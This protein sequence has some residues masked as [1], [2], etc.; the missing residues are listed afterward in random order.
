[1]A[2]SDPAEE[3]ALANYEL[4][5]ATFPQLPPAGR[6]VRVVILHAGQFADT[7][8][9]TLVN[10]DL[11]GTPYEALSYTWGEQDHDLKAKS[12]DEEWEDVEGDEVEEEGMP[13]TPSDGASTV[14]QRKTHNFITV[15]SMP[16][17]VMANLADALRH[18]RLA[19]VSRTLWIDYLCINQG[20]IQDR[21]IQ[22][23][24]MDEIYR[25]ASTVIVWLGLPS[26]DS[27]AGLDEVYA[28]TRN[29]HL[30]QT[31][32]SCR[33]H[34]QLMTRITPLMNLL[35]RPWFQRVWV[36]QEIAL[37]RNVI[38][39]I[40]TQSV[41]WNWFAKAGRVF[42]DHLEC[43]ASTVRPFN[44]GSADDGY[45]NLR[46]VWANVIVL[47]VSGQQEQLSL[48]V[49]LRFFYNRLASDPRDKVYALLGL[50]SSSER[51]LEADYT[52]SAAAVYEEVAIAIL[53]REKGL[54]VLIDIDELAGDVPDTPSWA[55]DW[56][57][58][59]VFGLNIWDFYKAAGST[60]TLARRCSPHTLKLQGLIVDN[61]TAVV[62]NRYE[63]GEDAEDDELLEAYRQLVSWETL[64]DVKAN[65]DA[66]Y[67]SGGTRR[68][69]FWQTIL[70]GVN[71]ARMRR[72]TVSSP[73][74]L[75]ANDDDDGDDISYGNWRAWLET[76]A[77]TPQAL[78]PAFLAAASRIPGIRAFS[79]VVVM[80]PAA[81]W[82]FVTEE[83]YMGLGPWD[84]E[85]G[86]VLVILAGGKMP[87]VLRELNKDCDVCNEDQWCYRLMGFA[88]AHGV[89]DGEM[90]SGI[91]AGEEEWISFCLR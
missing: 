42:H 35:S 17:R 71:A 31:Y 38:V 47:D 5:Y 69:A 89:M 41:P 14:D 53:N 8:N 88:Y 79:D 90:V 49:A 75:G 44:V 64:A 65:P 52:L 55:P 6:G 1:M 76:Y 26:A 20:S 59:T 2:S 66:P 10:G 73:A 39:Y 50:L 19:S 4:L 78:R 18:L 46:H 70:M 54:S 25:T 22:V 87:F 45:L 61:V 67:P 56:T 58:S 80:H 15:N 43:C 60:P 12:K 84:M 51:L 21:N 86:D 30:S 82:F 33:S 9:C 28:L 74:I 24:R 27:A 29:Q 91:E 3:E 40:G 23:G 57:T 13:T 77:Q 32:S 83:G 7:I 68:E 16:I 34:S 63:E 81:R 72:L 37:A 48:H 11:D 36:I 62:P 85:D